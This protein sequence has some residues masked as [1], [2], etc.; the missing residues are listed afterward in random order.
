MALQV[1]QNTSAILGNSRHNEASGLA[2]LLRNDRSEAERASRD[3][4]IA[5]A[6]AALASSTTTFSALYIG[7]IID[8]DGLI[9]RLSA[10]GYDVSVSSERGR[11]TLPLSWS[12][13]QN[14][15]TCCQMTPRAVLEQWIALLNAGDVAGLAN[16]YAQDA[17]NHQ[18]ALE[19]VHGREAIRAMLK[20][21]FASATMVCIVEAIHDAGDVIALEWR[22][23]LG[24]R[25]CGFFTIKDGLIAFQR[26][27]WDKLSFLRIH[28]LPL[29]P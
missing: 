4:W 24:L 13:I 10:R 14:Q 23:P 12:R 18:V 5:A 28:N 7:D 19:P 17:I 27:Y 20:R 3:R 15:P 29:D 8:P 16:L 9:A 11:A 6:E 25:G 1:R 2:T 26:G 22:D 21:E